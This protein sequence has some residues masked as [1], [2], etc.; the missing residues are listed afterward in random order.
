[1]KAKPYKAKSLSGAERQVRQLRKIVANLNEIAGR[2]KQ[3][4]DRMAMLAADGPC[5]SN[6]L[7]VAETKQ[8]R[9]K[10]LRESCGLRPDGR[11][12]VIGLR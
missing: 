12:L 10:I 9:D 8:L 11:S 4:R 2:F 5:F 7:V 6:P 3:E 1:M